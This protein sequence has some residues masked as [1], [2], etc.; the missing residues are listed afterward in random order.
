MIQT[1][2]ACGRHTQHFV[3]DIRDSALIRQIQRSHPQWAAAQGACARCVDLAFLAE[4]ESTYRLQIPS[5]I[6][7]WRNVHGLSIP[8]TPLR[9]GVN[10]DHTGAGVTIAM[11]DSGFYPHPDLIKPKSRLLRIVDITNPDREEEYFHRPHDESWHGTMTSVVCAGNGFLSG[12]YFRSLA[13]EAKL[14]LVKVHD[15]KKITGASIEKALRWVIRHKERYDIRIVNLSVTDDW[16]ISYKDSN[17]DQAAHDAMEA[18]LVVVAAVGNDPTAPIKPPANSPDVIAVGGVD[19]HTTIAQNDDSLYHSTFGTT[20]DGFLKPDLMAPA[21]WIAAPILPRTPN[22][23]E[24]RFLFD[25]WKRHDK[26]LVS[27]LRQQFNLT[28]LPA[29]ILSAAPQVIRQAIRE[30]IQQAR[31]ITPHYQH[32]DGT[33][34]AAPIVCSVV[35]QMLE[36]A[37]QLTPVQVRQILVS[38][39]RRLPDVPVERQGHGVLDVGKVIQMTLEEG[40]HHPER[41]THSPLIDSRGSKIHFFYHDHLAQSVALAGS[42]NR[43]NHRE[44]MLRSDGKGRW[45]VSIPLLPKGI[46]VYKFVVDGNKWLDDPRNPFSE[47]DGFNGLNSRLVIE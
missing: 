16:P 6:E 31:Y 7:N 35:A 4:H 34:F 5:D 1:C 24:A 15:G 46:Y 30:R 44:Y 19:D 23:E 36:I 8:P 13:P 42:F 33:S 12:G 26:S 25:L 41:R 2:P 32:S 3:R 47:S 39:A 38:T 22:S 29:D 43:W 45:K 17:V 27:Q 11:I 28:K 9:L 21:I 18:G 14:V 10:G 20:V 40:R 37:P